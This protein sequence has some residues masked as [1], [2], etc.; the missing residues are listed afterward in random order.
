MGKN[1]SRSQGLSYLQVLREKDELIQGLRQELRRSMQMLEELQRQC[2]LQQQQVDESALL[3]AGKVSDLEYK[4]QQIQVLLQER[5]QDAN[6]NARFSSESSEKKN[7]L[8][9]P[10]IESLRA[11]LASKEQRMEQ[12]SKKFTKLLNDQRK[13]MVQMQKLRQNLNSSQ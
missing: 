5:D 3:L 11:Q 9:D 4:E 6:M 8:N 10:L 1:S 12:V 7:M 13:Y 2:D